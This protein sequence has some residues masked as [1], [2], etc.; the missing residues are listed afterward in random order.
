M[1][2]ER[3]NGL[4]GNDGE[5]NVL[6]TSASRKVWLVRAFQRAVEAE[7]GG[8]VIAVDASPYS[9]LCTQQTKR[10]WCRGDCDGTFLK[11]I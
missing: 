4:G 10:I 9:R 6:I 1:M 8:L 5:M 7:G 11:R 3:M 2:S